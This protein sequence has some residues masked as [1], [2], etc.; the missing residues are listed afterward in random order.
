MS[1]SSSWSLQIGRW[2]G[3]PIRVHAIFFAVAVLALFLSISRP[4]QE[5][6]GYG[7]LSIAVLLASVLVHEL[8]HCLAAARAGVH[9]EQIVLGPLGGLMPTHLPREPQAELITA[10]AGPVVSF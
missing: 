6:A 1:D 8:G 3:V 7:L 10:L 5:A 4:G 9:P 2:R